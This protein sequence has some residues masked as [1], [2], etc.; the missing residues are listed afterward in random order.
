MQSSS[1][2]RDQLITDLA[3]SLEESSGLELSI[4]DAQTPFLELGLDSLFLTQF[5]LALGR[6]FKIKVTFRQLL[7]HYPTM[8]SLAV[9]IEATLPPESRRPE[10]AKSAVAPAPAAAPP[11]A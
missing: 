6:K 8:E 10:S 4:S 5:A 7:E 1:S 9:H 11:P 2:R 3:D